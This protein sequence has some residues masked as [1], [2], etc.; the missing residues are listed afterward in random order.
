M[1]GFGVTQRRPLKDCVESPRMFGQA[2]AVAQVARCGMSRGRPVSL[3]YLITMKCNARC[4]MCNY[5]K[6][7]Y[8]PESEGRTTMT[9]EQIDA[10]SRSMGRLLQIQISGGEPFLRKDMGDVMLTM[11]RNCRPVYMTI[12]TNCSTPQRIIE[13]V[14]R[15]C[16]E[17]PSMMVRMNPSIDGYGEQHDEIRKVP[18]LY[19]KCRETITK[20]RELQKK[21]KNLTVNLALVLTNYNVEGI[22]ETVD[23]L[24]EDL[25]PDHFNVMM[26]R[27]DTPDRKTLEVPVEEYERIAEKVR[28]EAKPKNGTGHPLRS[29]GRV[30]EKEVT[31]YV[32]QTMKEKRQV[33]PCIG[34]TKH[35]M[36][37]DDG[38][39]LPCDILKP[40]L[41]HNPT[42]ELP[43]PY[44]ARLADHNYSVPDA[45]ASSYA[46]KV[47][48]FVQDGKCWCTTECLLTPSILLQPSM[49]PRLAKTALKQFIEDMAFPHRNGHHTA[50][51]DGALNTGSG[52]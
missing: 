11:A 1:L 23:K 10:F 47:A 46:Q 20:L 40:F 14:D 50:T 41:L 19:E 16:A 12:P 17:F 2:K 28:S 21:H 31:Y 30:L 9:L 36:I 35:I 13:A 51:G 24:R 27:G 44:M 3:V 5:W 4:K 25:C 6:E 48:Q 42:D 37:D 38:S 32:A 49:Y 39:I 45:L 34:G 18:G 8:G 29:L 15:L 26:A 33:V 22:D 52:G 7:V 43:S